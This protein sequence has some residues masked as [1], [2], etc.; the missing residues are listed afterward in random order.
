MDQLE[1][2]VNE[3]KTLALV[4]F[5]FIIWYLLSSCSEG[6]RNYNYTPFGT[7]IINDGH[8]VIRGSRNNLFCSS[9]ANGLLCNRDLAGPDETFLVQSLGNNQYAFKSMK[10]GL[11]CSHTT[12][13]LRCISA[14]IGD[15]EVFNLTHLGE[16]KYSIQSNRNKRYCSDSGHGLVCD[17]PNMYGWEF[18]HFEFIKVPWENIR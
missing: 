10:T 8:Y 11:W 15:W 14:T 4:A 9:T 16:G 6:F 12:T 18:Q 2:W 5:I 13:G 17:V 7:N 3:N 1:I